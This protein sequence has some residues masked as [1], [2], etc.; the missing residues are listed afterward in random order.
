M[1]LEEARKLPFGEDYFHNFITTEELYNLHIIDDGY[2]V[3]DNDFGG[4][5]PKKCRCGSDMVVYVN[6]DLEFE[7][8]SHLQRVQCCN[9]NCS[10][11]MSYGLSQMFSRFGVK[12]LGPA[13][14]ANL[15]DWARPSFKVDSYVEILFWTSYKDFPV[16]L[17]N[18]QAMWDLQDALD[19]IHSQSFTFPELVSKLGIPEFGSSA[20]EIFSGIGNAEQFEEEI[21]KNGI[22]IF[23]GLR[24]VQSAGKKF[25]LAQSLKDIYCA[26]Y[27]LAPNLRFEGLH[28]I[29]V[30]ITGRVTPFG[31]SMT[32][33]EFINLCNKKARLKNGFPLFEIRMT[34]AIKTTDFIIAD[35]ESNTAK[36]REGVARGVLIS[37]TDFL[38]RLEAR[39]E[40]E[41]EKLEGEN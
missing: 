36:Y 21:N 38:K 10:I 26:S 31:Q 2:F 32:K 16:E 13:F 33:A 41:N 19:F 25:W 7:D 18:Y 37:S 40:K 8:E 11:K 35:Y 17:L 3:T 15:I 20:K 14:C 9:P 34:T 5:F 1:T 39:I 30:V 4:A 23:L 29:D 6:K 24:N 12:G 22:S 27:A 28:D